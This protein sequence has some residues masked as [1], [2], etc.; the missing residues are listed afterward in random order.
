MTPREGG[1]AAAG[2][3]IYHCTITTLLWDPR[4]TTKGTRG[5]TGE[6]RETPEGPEGTRGMQEAPGGPE[7]NHGGIGAGRKATGGSSSS[8]FICFGT[9]GLQSHSPVLLYVVVAIIQ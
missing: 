9:S 2:Q 5:H 1:T 6:S 7:G 4:D 3:K 8:R